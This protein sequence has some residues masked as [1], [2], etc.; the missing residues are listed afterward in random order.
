MKDD[1]SA[2]MRAASAASMRA[3]V[4]VSRTMP[5]GTANRAAAKKYGARRPKAS[6]TNEP[7]S[8]PNAMPP[9]AN[10]R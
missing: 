7:A 10:Q 3:V 8:A 5:N 2:A 4:K 1:G 9:A 6:A